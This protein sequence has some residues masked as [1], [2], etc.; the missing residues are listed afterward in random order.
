MAIGRDIYLDTRLIISKLEKLF[1]PSPSHPPLSTKETLGL[2]GLMQKLAIEGSLFREIVKNIPSN[3]PLL[4]DEKFQKDRAGFFFQPSFNRMEVKLV[5][6]E[7]IVNLRHLFDVLEGL[8]EDG[9]EWVGGTKQPTLADLEGLWPLDWF[10]MD[11]QPSREYFSESIYPKVYG[12]RRRF[13]AVLEEAKFSRKEKAVRIK[14]EQAARI[15]TGSEFTDGELVVD[16]DD[17]LK[18]KAGMMVELFPL[19]GGGYSHQDRGRL[20]KLTKDEVAI[21][22]QAK[23]GE[24][25]RVHAPRW[26][27]RVKAIARL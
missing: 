22:V 8:F 21:A 23:S 18:L 20:V 11:L 19:D 6:P 27:F 10:I 26:Q 9:R 1:P 14:G 15:V 12:W 7:G 17:P 5:R 3:F 24:E 4:R 16:G 25:V 13:R 2:A